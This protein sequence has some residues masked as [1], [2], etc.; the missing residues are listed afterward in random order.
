M[1]ATASAG[2]IAIYQKSSDDSNRAHESSENVNTREFQRVENVKTREFQR[3]ENDNQRAHEIE[4]IRLQNEENERQRA[5]QKLMEDSRVNQSK[6][7]EQTKELDRSSRQQLEKQKVD[8]VATSEGPKIDSVAASQENPLP[9]NIGQLSVS[10]LERIVK[11]SPRT[12]SVSEAG[13]KDS[14]AS[15]LEEPFFCLRWLSDTISYFFF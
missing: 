15:V 11:N 6:F 7:D 2:I 10:D 4:L 5:H 3:V 8:S 12:S 9:A 14:I 1:A 13:S